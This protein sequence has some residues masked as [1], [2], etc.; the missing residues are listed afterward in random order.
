MTYLLVCSVFLNLKKTGYHEGTSTP[1]ARFSFCFD[2]AR[3]VAFRPCLAAGSA[4]RQ[5]FINVTID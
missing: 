2:A 5:N 3:T 1:A 4:F